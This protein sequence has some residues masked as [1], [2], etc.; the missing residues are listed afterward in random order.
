MLD[1]I[2]GS[3]IRKNLLEIKAINGSNLSNYAALD[4]LLRHARETVPAYKNIDILNLSEFPVV[5]KNI[6]RDNLNEHLSNK[7]EIKDLSSTTTSG[8]TGTPFKIY[9]DNGKIIRHKAAL[10]YWNELAGAPLGQRMYYLRVWN[11]LTRKSKLKQFIE[12]I[13]PIDVSHFDKDA[14]QS[15]ITQISK[16]KCAILG[17]SASISELIKNTPFFPK[18][19]KGIIGMSEHLSQAVRN[20]A[21]EK[22]GFPII[23]RYSNMENG[24]IAQQFDISD[25][26]LIN[27]A[28]YIIEIFHPEKDE[29]LPDGELGR[30][31]VTDLYNYAMP[32]IRY[33]TGDLG[34]IET[35]QDGKRVFKSVEGRK[36]D[37]IFDTF[38]NPVSSH[39]ISI[40]LWAFREIIQYQFIQKDKGKYLMKINCGDYKFVKEAELTNALKK[41]LGDEALI[42]FEYVDEI[43]VLNSGK[44][45]YIINEYKK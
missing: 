17:F 40:S 13:Y 8:S 45:R 39:A 19:I 36:S 7:F 31:I 34:T 20:E 3:K 10:I 44:R 11:D 12:N 23:A 42:E 25:D 26:Y 33:D 22:L 30:I 1:R 28:D 27:Q 32:F 43:P 16:T 18:N 37:L 35:R 14:V 4:N 38:D 29:P 41:Y 21:F 2:K 15:F 5:N 24:F 6:L 9:F